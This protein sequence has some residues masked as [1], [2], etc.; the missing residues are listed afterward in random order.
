MH[1]SWGASLRGKAPETDTSTPDWQLIIQPDKA[2]FS[3]SVCELMVKG[4]KLYQTLTENLM[5]LGVFVLN[6]NQR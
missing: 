4:T 5:I 3:T 6:C 2:L 1:C